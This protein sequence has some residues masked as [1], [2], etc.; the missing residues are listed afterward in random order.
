MQFKVH[1]LSLSGPIREVDVY[2]ASSILNF[3]RLFIVNVSLIVYLSVCFSSSL[4]Y[5]LI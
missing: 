3:S 5:R 2:L 1:N 4:Y